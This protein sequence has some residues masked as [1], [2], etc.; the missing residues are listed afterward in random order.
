MGSKVEKPQRPEAESL[1]AASPLSVPGH[2][3]HGSQSCSQGVVLDPSSSSSSSNAPSVQLKEVDNVNMPTASRGWRFYGA[4]GTLCL[5]TF[6]IALDSTI[7]CVALPVSFES[8]RARVRSLT[9]LLLER[10]SQKT[11]EHQPSRLSGAA[12][13]SSS[14]RQSS[15]PPSPPYP[16]SLAVDRL[17]SAP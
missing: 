5:V 4:F 7:I 2:T 3:P 14:P 15:S 1:P 13:V 8:A 9:D 12:L 10:P 16:T 6:I 11:L 17:F